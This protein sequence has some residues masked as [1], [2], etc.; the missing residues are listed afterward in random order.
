[1]DENMKWWGEQ[2]LEQTVKAL[3]K[4]GMEAAWVA[5]SQE[6]RHRVLEMIPAGASVGIGGSITVRQIGLLSALQESGYTVFQHW[7][8]NIT[9]EERLQI[10]QSAK[11]A[12]VYL[13]SVNAVTREGE[14]VNIDMTGNRVSSM[15]FGPAKVILIVG[16]NKIVRD[17]SEGIWRAKN[18]ATPPN[19]RRLGAKTPCAELGYCTDCDSPGRLCRAVTIIERKPTLTDLTV[20]LVNEELGY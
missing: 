4:H 5:D 20:I 15:I 1:M 10:L 6:A 18:I 16:G 8:P 2:A 12:D 19:A 13:S 9:K 7:Q 14:L 3:Q 11:S 17:V